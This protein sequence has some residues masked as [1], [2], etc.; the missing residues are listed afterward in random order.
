MR[1]YITQYPT[2]FH[3]DRDCGNLNGSTTIHHVEEADAEDDDLRPCS[4]CGYLVPTLSD[5]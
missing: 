2:C 4:V 3:R 5:V 1:V